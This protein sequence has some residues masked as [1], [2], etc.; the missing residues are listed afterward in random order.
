MQNTMFGA[1]DNL[2][3]S[4]EYTSA[5]NTILAGDSE[6][7]ALLSNGY[8]I[9]SIHPIVKNVVQAD[10]TVTSTATTAVVTLQNGTTGYSIVHVDV[11]NSK[12]LYIDTT[13]RTI[14][15]KTTS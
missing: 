13:T 3:V 4:E 11:E 5:V 9:T 1:Q 15:D 12:V 8:N 10:G 7:A 14:I 6:T 2:E